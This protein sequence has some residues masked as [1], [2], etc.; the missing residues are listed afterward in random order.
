MFLLHNSFT[1]CLF[2]ELTIIRLQAR[3]PRLSYTLLPH[4]SQRTAGVP[5]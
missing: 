5:L 4:P 1:Y 3:I 2:V